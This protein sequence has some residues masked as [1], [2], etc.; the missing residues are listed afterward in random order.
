VSHRTRRIPRLAALLLLG[1]LVTACSGLGGGLKEDETVLFLPTYAVP[2]AGGGWRVNLHGWVFEPERDSTMRELFVQSVAAHAEIPEQGEQRNRFEERLRGFLVDNERGK[3]L[4]V[5]LDGK[6]F[7]LPPTGANGHS[8]SQVTL[9]GCPLPGR[10]SGECADWV[11]YRLAAE[12]RRPISGLVRLIPETGISVISDI[13]DTIKISHVTDTKQMLRT[14]FLDEYR[15]VPG[16]SDL[17]RRWEAQGAAFHYLSASPWQLYPALSDF[18]DASGFPRGVF[19]LA[20]YRLKDETVTDLFR[21]PYDKKQAALERL[22]GDFPRR[23]FVLVGDSGQADPEVYG[24]LACAHPGQVRAIYIRAVEGS[25]LSDGRFA[26]AFRCV[27]EGLGL[28]FM[29][30]GE[31]RL[32]LGDIATE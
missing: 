3:V 5:S 7:A 28:L 19:H 13:D 32:S 21:S 20:V 30:A 22:L 25:D 17:Y 8:E 9:P 27:G 29:D 11:D 10:N 1:T 2:E 23:R 4:N 15:P 12:H 14:A 24:D 26:K 31:I 6:T 18:A 16:M